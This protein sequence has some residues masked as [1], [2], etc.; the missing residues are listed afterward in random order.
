MRTLF[1][2]TK[3]N[4]I[5][6]NNRFIRSATWENKAD[7]KGH[8][9]DELLKVYQELA[10][11]QVGLIITGY[12][13]VIKDEQPN[14]G[15]MGIYDD[16]FIKDYKKLTDAVH[17]HGSKIVLQIAYGGTQTNYRPENR[18]IWGP[19]TVPEMATGVVAHEM[20]KDD[21]NTLVKAFGDAASRAKSA[22][23]DGVEFHGAHGYLLSQFLNPYHNQRTDE[24][25]GDIENRARVIF[26][27]YNEIRRRVGED[28][29]VMIK[30]N[31]RDFVEQE[32]TF[33]ES[34]YVCKELSKRGIDAIEVSGG[35]AAAKELGAQRKKINSTE[36]EAYFEEYAAE[37]AEQVDTKVI[38][39][40]GIRS[41]DVMDRLLSET[42][43][44]YFSMAR[45]FLS[46]PDLVKH[47]QEKSKTKA[48]C[49]SCGS[50]YTPEGNYCVTFSK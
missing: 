49:V 13:F 46:E 10:K 28:Y 11:G 16:S 14:P 22:G 3:I 19:S 45:P 40:G 35:I 24:Y 2:S 43:I 4:N 48:R 33:E 7:Q 36:K 25:G 47:F 32:L 15:M 20:T 39:V 50:C 17:Q 30:I 18:V 29:A 8:L 38:L 21:I 26:E 41:L 34:L 44:D 37:I 42:K 31:C 23:F 5:E 9:T 1:D 27:T 6:L 12:A